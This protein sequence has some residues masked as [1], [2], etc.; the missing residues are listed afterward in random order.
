VTRE[1]FPCALEATAYF[2]VAE[3]LTNILR[4]AQATSAWITAA[5]DDGRLRLEVRDDGIGGAL[6]NG[7]NGMLAIRDRAAAANGTLWLE[8]P[9]GQGTRVTASLPIGAAQAVESAATSR[10]LCRTD[11]RAD[12]P[13]S[14]GGLRGPG[15][16]HRLAG[17]A[18]P[19]QLLTSLHRDERSRCTRREASAT[20]APPP[21]KPSIPGCFPE[22]GDLR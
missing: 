7:S 21:T 13:T 20:A 4:H 18:T 3:A 1:R 9:P 8:S 5:V 14:D 10:D 17:L 22:S 11:N 16:V 12:I 19:T 15:S 2:I 6:M